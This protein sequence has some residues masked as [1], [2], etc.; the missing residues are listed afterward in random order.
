MK[1]VS[2]KSDIVSLNMGQFMAINYVQPSYESKLFARHKAAP[3]KCLD[4]DGTNDK[5]KLEGWLYMYIVLFFLT[6]FI[7]EAPFYWEFQR[8][9]NFLLGILE[10]RHHF[11]E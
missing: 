10:R 3:I 11:I 1:P 6:L 8:G 2:S 7:T 4:L 9:G 5:L